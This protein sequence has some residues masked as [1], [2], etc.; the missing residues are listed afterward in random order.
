MVFTKEDG[1][2]IKVF[3]AEYGLQ[4]QKVVGRNFLTRTGLFSTGP[5]S[6]ADWRYRVCR[7][8]VR[9]QQRTYGLHKRQVSVQMATTLSINCNWW[10]CVRR[11]FHIGNLCFW[12]PFF[13]QLLLRNCA[14]NFVEICN[15]CTRK[16]TIKAAKRIFNS[17]KICGSYCDFYFGVTFFGTHCIKSIHSYSWA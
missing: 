6:A 4:C 5:T 2:L 14:V 3:K 17:D 12:V 16:V 11:L 9:Q 8:E 15:I 10:Y 7:Q 13:K 1:I